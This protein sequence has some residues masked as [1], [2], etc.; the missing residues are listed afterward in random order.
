MQQLTYA[1]ECKSPEFNTPSR[2]LAEFIG[3][4]YYDC[5]S[6]GM[7]L[8]SLIACRLL[9]QRFRLDTSE[10]VYPSEDG[11]FVDSMGIRWDTLADWMRR[12]DFEEFDPEMVQVVEEV[13][14]G[15]K[16]GVLPAPFAALE[17]QP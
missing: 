17:Y 13:L 6:G 14:F 11:A 10:W 1:C 7:H 2:M 3:T 5:M 16:F 4:D 8:S 12:T 9:I 15:R